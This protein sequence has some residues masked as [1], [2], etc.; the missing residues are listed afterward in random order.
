M[1]YL[2][3]TNV[4]IRFLNGRSRSIQQELDKHASENILLCSVV[5]AELLVGA[6]KN[7]DPPSRL[8]IIQRFLNRFASLSFD[9]SAAASYAE[10]RA[11][12]EKQGIPIGPNDLLIAA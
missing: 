6:L 11:D 8:R 3:D 1:R 9:D 4:C 7:E 2:L 10:I 12:L 5:K